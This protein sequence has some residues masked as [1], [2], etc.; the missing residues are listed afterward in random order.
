MKQWALYSVAV[1]SG[2]LLPLHVGA[3]EMTLAKDDVAQLWF[4]IVGRI[5][6]GDD[7]KVKGM[8]VD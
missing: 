6:E 8:L 1:F 3:A 4:Q 5:V 2:G 7:L